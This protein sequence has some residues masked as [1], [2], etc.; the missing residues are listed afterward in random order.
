VTPDS[1]L[2]FLYRVIKLGEGWVQQVFVLLIITALPNEAGLPI[3]K[4]SYWMIS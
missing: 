4:I 3:E 2:N 1:D